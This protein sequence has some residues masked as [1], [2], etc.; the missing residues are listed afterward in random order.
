MAKRK[1]SRLINW[2]H[3]VEIVPMADGV[4]LKIVNPTCGD[5]RCPGCHG[6]SVTIW[7]KIV[8]TN[9]RLKAGDFVCW[10]GD[11]LFWRRPSC[12]IQRI[13]KYRR[14]KDGAEKGA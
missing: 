7:T 11:K 12:S 2:G 13:G 5:P 3:I 9:Y 14:V 1:P 8:K 4:D 6:V 10:K